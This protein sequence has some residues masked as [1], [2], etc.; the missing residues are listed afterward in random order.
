MKKNILSYPNR[1]TTLE[2]YYKKVKFYLIRP[3][4]FIFNSFAFSHLTQGLCNAKYYKYISPI[5]A[6]SA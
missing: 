6:Q 2:Y 4:P 3:K 5:S 1:V